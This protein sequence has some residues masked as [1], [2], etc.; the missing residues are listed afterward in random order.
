MRSRWS[1]STTESSEG[2]RTSVYIRWKQ[3][4]SLAFEALG[5]QLGIGHCERDSSVVTD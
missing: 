3:L 5:E 2:D 4:P 1:P